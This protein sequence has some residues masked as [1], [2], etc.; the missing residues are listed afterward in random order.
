M[1]KILF[2]IPP[3]IPFDDFLAPRSTSKQVR[4]KDGKLYGSL[5]TDMPLGALSL[6]AYIK[7]YCKTDVETELLDFNIE[8]NDI[9]T[10][11]HA[12]PMEYYEEYLRNQLAVEPDIIAL[13]ALF[14]SSYFNILDIAA[15]CRKVFPDA[16]MLAGGSV[17]TSMYAYLFNATDDFDAVCYGEGELPFAKLI[18][19]E[20][21]YALLDKHSSWITR[22]KIDENAIFGHEFIEDLDEIPFYDY[23]ICKMEKYGANPAI[24]AYG[25]IKDKVDNFHIMTSRGC[26]FRCT[27]CA[28]HKVHGRS[29]RY[30]SMP[31]V[32]D[33]LLRLRDQYGA[34]IFVFQDDHF[35]AD[36]ERA[37]EIARYVAD[38]GVKAVFQ[39]GL[40]L[41][42][43]D[44]D[45]LKVLKS[46]GADQLVLP[47]ESGSARVLKEIMRKPLK[48]SIAERVADDCRELGIYTNVNILIGMPGET[49][50]DIEDSRQFL[51]K[52]NANWKII[53]VATPL[54][55]AEMHDICVEK[56]YI[57]A[58]DI[59]CDFRKAVVETEDFTAQYIQEISYDI[60]LDVNFI[61][62]IDFKLGEYELALKGFETAIRAKDDH[63]LA[64]HYASMCY[65]QLGDLEKAKKYQQVAIHAYENDPVWKN[66]FDKFNIS[67]YNHDLNTHLQVWL[68]P[69]KAS[70]A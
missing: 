6:S 15:C 36:T 8:L 47:V 38:L 51:R 49:K 28:S 32:K 23:D 53:V 52:L 44:K 3:H 7:Q 70:V 5:V 31:R 50:K 68:E 22:K 29:M 26:P 18:D 30:Y 10:F 62:N 69:E 16:L 67:P 2:I 39:N 63:G 61:H 12:S 45:M 43:L 40:T 65:E 46:A 56:N 24:M 60:N 21:R 17:P 33:D 59:G 48:L 4:K 25:S 58:A 27:F 20:D 37:K 66:A 34:K 42:A 19:A 55:G 57:N 54:V 1:T 35:M 14:S 9:D 13:S 11:S 64:Y 41:Y